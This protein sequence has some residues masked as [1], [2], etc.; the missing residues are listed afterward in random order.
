[1][2][3][4][5]I[6]REVLS[7]PWAVTPEFFT[8]VTSLLALRASGA[9]LTDEEIE[10]RIAPGQERA[11]SRAGG[12][13]AGSVAVMS[14]VG[15][16]LPRAEVLKETS[17]AMSVQ[18]IAAHFRQ[19]VT[20]DTVGA[21]VLDFDSPGGSVSGIAEFADAVYEARSHKPIIAV[22]NATMASA[23]YFIGAS[24][25]TVFA[26]PSA[27]VGAIGVFAAHKDLS[28]ALE[29]A[30]VKISLVAAGKN[31][32]L[33]NEFEPLTDEG[34]AKIQTVVDAFYGQFVKAVARGRGVSQSAVRE[35]FGEGASVTA[36]QAL[37]LG[38]ID[39]VGTLDDAIALA[40]RRAKSAGARADAAGPP[41]VAETVVA[42][43]VASPVVPDTAIPTAEATPATDGDDL[44]RRK[45]RLRLAG[46]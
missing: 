11:A 20:D 33:G 2:R 4:E 45:R 17:G 1:M 31:K 30:G 13:R 9:R 38:M 26:T 41:F 36:E 29:K 19:L 46:R 5:Y 44:E 23:A 34:R 43:P 42:E 28:A 12:P 25:S 21:I 6:L 39:Q 16:L 3:Y 14:I 27:T 7:Q 24:A 37:K 40:A 35:G 10:A 22:A 32:V 18:Q 8:H 15:V